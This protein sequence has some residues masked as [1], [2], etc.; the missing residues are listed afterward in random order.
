M[1]DNKGLSLIIVNNQKGGDY[2]SQLKDSCEVEQLSH[3]A[4]QYA[5]NNRNTALYS[6]SRR[7]FMSKKIIKDGFIPTMRHLYL[8]KMICLRIRHF[9]GDILRF[10]RI[11]K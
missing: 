5:Y 6:N 1:D 7:L 8:M 9:G 11:K 2:L 3:S 10:L 4:V